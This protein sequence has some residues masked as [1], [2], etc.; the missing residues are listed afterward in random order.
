MAKTTTTDKQVVV[1]I[2]S[3]ADF[4]AKVAALGLNMQVEETE[5]LYLLKAIDG[6]KMWVHQVWKSSY[7]ADRVVVGVSAQQEAADQADFES[8]QK[9]AAQAKPATHGTTR[10]GKVLVQQTPA[11]VGST[12]YI[13]SE[14]DDYGSRH[15]VGGGTMLKV[16]HSVGGGDSPVDVDF[17]CAINKTYI[18]SGFATWGGCQRDRVSLSVFA[19]GSTVSAGS[20]TYFTT[21]NYPGHPWHGKLILP[22]AGN[23]NLNVTAPVPVGFYFSPGSAEDKPLPKYWNATWNPAT[24]QYGGIA[25]APGGD[26]EFNMF[27]EATQLYRFINGILLDGD[28]F[29]PWSV[30]SDDTQRLGDGMFLRLTP[31][32]NPQVSD[33]AWRLCAILSMHREYT[34]L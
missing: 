10:D 18:H 16:E 6:L 9:A 22:A 3:Y 8:N 19:K 27:T 14:G 29:A 20:G 11:P 2:G 13:T 31:T 5:K 24:Q 28:N 26:G 15:S 30:E 12:T 21:L 7:L 17:N 34:V 33:H 23:G 1:R 32:T 4:K 25:A